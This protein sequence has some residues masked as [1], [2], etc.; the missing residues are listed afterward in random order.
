MCS[1]N[2]EARRSSLSATKRALLEQRK[3]GLSKGFARATV[4]ARRDGNGAAPL[5]YA[6]QRLW[7][8]DQLQPG[9]SAYNIPMAFWLNGPLDVYALERSFSK[10]VDRHEVLRS[11]IV[12]FEGEP[13]QVV[14]ESIPGIFSIVDLLGLSEQA[15]EAEVRRLA[16]VEANRPFDLT[17]GPLLRVTLLLLGEQSYSVLLT[18]HH[19]VS[20]A[21]SIDVLVG[22]LTV[23]YN[24]FSTESDLSL[25]ELKIQYADYAVWERDHLRG[26]GLERQFGYWRQKLGGNL[27]I[28]NLPTNHARPPRQTFR[29]D[30]ESFILPMDLS[31]EIKSLARKKDATLFV[32]LLSAF[33][34]LLY[35]LTG[36]G[37]IIVGTDIAN[38]N[39][40]ETENLI[41]Y[42][43]NQLALR[44]DLSDNPDFTELLGRVRE[45]VL[46]AY[47]HSEI[48]F[49]RL[50]EELQPVRDTSRNPI[51]QVL[52]VLQNVTV[53]KLALPGL[54]L[55]PMTV[56]SRT[57][58][59]DLALFMTEGPNGLSGIW[60]YSTDLFL[61]S[62]IG[63]FTKQFEK[64]LK[65]I[66]SQPNE[67]LT[68]LEI[69][70]ED[71]MRHQAM[72]RDKRKEYKLKKF[73]SVRP[74]AMSLSDAEMIKTRYMSEGARLPLVIE[75]ASDQVDIIDW[76]KGNLDYLEKELLSHG[77][78]LFRGCDINSTAKFEQLAGA[79]CNHL[80]GEYG[81]LPREEVSGNVY[82]STPYPSDKAILFHNESS[83]LNKWPLRIWFYCVKA[84]AVGG[85][86]PLVDC[87]KLYRL[88]A[89][90]IISRFEYKQILYVRNFIEGLDVSWESFFKTSDRQEVE[91]RC[92][93]SGIQWQ[94]RPNNTLAISHLRPAVSSHVK[95]GEKVFF[96]QMQLHHPCCL[97]PEVRESLLSIYGKKGLPRNVYY[98]DGTEI[99][100]A[101]I[102]EISR[103]YEECA[104][105]NRWEE[106]DVLMV[107]NML[108]AHG[109]KQYRGERKIV[110]AMGEMI[111]QISND[112]VLERQA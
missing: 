36:Q 97:E 87:R 16:R 23:A 12:S 71:D 48:P 22:E 76:A 26:E 39:H 40:R 42:F 29:G 47:S 63:R 54:A 85:E 82:S 35:R 80:Y 99:D 10:I 66:L 28:L 31:S 30:Y 33:L 100:D 106:G 94:W 110:V 38:R 98:G 92:R 37:E 101:V 112:Q 75:P 18:M 60:N 50:V 62:T 2:I 57:A 5:S 93:A 51:F 44:A 8:M 55:R 34:A 81:D 7:F 102:E 108:V 78:I 77:A 58:K 86:T 83:H 21:W 107:D 9:N 73:M 49:D 27:S 46:G 109:R 89:P 17:K 41:G 15:R 79:V 25:P 1:Q 61:P 6:Q 19:L 105:S 74:K 88:I 91:R 70:D 72:E 53:R 52:F 11:N 24:A 32:T 68:E 45:I 84:S 3:R 14:N 4:I 111:E 59:F 64:L 104:I 65:G 96:N 103:A 20:D 90:E 95:T 67:R 13:W 69:Q 56:D 43:I